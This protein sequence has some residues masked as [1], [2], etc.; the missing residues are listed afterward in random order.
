[1]KKHS[2]LNPVKIAYL[3]L[4]TALAI[5]L[6]IPQLPFPLATFLKYDLAGIPIA[7]LALIDIKLGTL[8]LPI[9]WLGAAY[10]TTDPTKII[11]PTM[12][13][14]AEAF[15]ALPLAL[16][17][18]KFS[19]SLGL[20]RASAISFAVALTSRV[21]VMLLLN[22]VITPYWLVWAKWMKTFETAYDFTIKFLPYIALFNASIVCYKVPIAL[23]AWKSINRFVSSE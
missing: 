18:K 9:F 23:G 5:A 7:L 17:F 1:M 11:G 19:K 4:F 16:T 14:I 6:H 12:K 2:S 15:T 13:V 22:Y 21:I 8:S 10:I 3:L 20:A